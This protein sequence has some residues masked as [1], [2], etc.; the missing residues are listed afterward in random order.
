[1][2][3]IRVLL[4]A[5]I[6]SN[7]AQTLER[8][9]AAE[10]ET[11]FLDGLE[12]IARAV[13]SNQPVS[14]ITPNGEPWKSI[15]ATMIQGG[16][17]NQ[18]FLQ[19]LS[20]LSSDLQVAISG[21]VS[22]RA[23]QIHQYTQTQAPPGKR[24]KT[25]DYLNILKNLGYSFKYNLCTNN[26]EVNGKPITD[27]LAAEIRGKLRDAGAEHINAAEDAYIAHA[28]Q[29]RYHP[30]RDYFA[31]LT[32][33]GQDV[34]TE[35]A[36][37]F[38]DANNIFPLFLKRWL[39]GSVARIMQRAQN[40]MLV[41]DARQGFGK[42]Y[43]SRWLCSPMPEYYHEGAIDPDDK[44]CRIRLM[45]TW[46]WT[47]SELG[48]TTRTRDRESLKSFL[49]LETVKDR[50]PYGHFDIQ[51][52]AIASFLGTINN[53]GGFL[54]DPTGNRRFMVCKMLDVDWAYSK[55]DV[56][57]IW[58]QAYDLYLTDEPWNLTD[59]ELT[60]ANEI[61]D[62]YQIEDLTVAA[63]KKYFRI[64]KNEKMWWVSTMDIVEH[65]ESKGV[66]FGSQIAASMAIGRAMTVID[67]EKRTERIRGQQQRGFVGL[68]II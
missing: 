43:F 22:T 30:L 67:L 2:T 55:L 38:Q 7:D 21:A 8:H 6:D 53:E 44:D 13:A 36:S 26:I 42:D 31:S 25:G 32:Y 59:D 11:D 10:P 33:Q 37:Y 52:P 63:I 64:D 15:H 12:C 56:E 62:G 16:D 20:N 28:W 9:Y 45:S 17:P 14:L 61:N 35:L 27:S 46:I 3:F 39:V 29:N 24:K 51:G 4:N 18:A 60:Q 1:M 65:L 58:A 41:L 40:R 34:I 68:Q 19:A 48:S 66:K 47:V 50:K 54:S 49:T 57:Q 5:G 23:G